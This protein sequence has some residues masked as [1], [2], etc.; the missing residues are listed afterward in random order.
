VLALRRGAQAARAQPF[1]E[2]AFRL[3]ATGTLHAATIMRPARR[4]K[5]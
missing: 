1:G 2:A 3:F 4:V 5:I